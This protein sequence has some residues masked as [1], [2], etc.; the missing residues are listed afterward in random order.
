MAV[1]H[2]VDLYTDGLGALT[3]VHNTNTQLVVYLFSLHVNNHGVRTSP[4][5]TGRRPC[6]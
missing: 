5:A 6:L 4:A 2:T 3:Q 1:A